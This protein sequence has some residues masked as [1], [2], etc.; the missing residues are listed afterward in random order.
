MTLAERDVPANGTNMRVR[1]AC[2]QDVFRELLVGNQD[3]LERLLGGCPKLR[4]LPV[5]ERANF[6]SRMLKRSKP[7]ASANECHDEPTCVVFNPSNN[8]ETNGT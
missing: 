5:F 7:A 3:V 8:K 1:T 4:S 2:P 6:Y